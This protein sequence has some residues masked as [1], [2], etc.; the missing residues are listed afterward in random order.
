M[1]SCS[2]IP[3]FHRNPSNIH[4]SCSFQRFVSRDVWPLVNPIYKF[5]GQIILQHFGSISHCRF[6]V[7]VPIFKANNINPYRY[8]NL[9]V[10]LR[11]TRGFQSVFFSLLGYRWLR[12]VKLRMVFQRFRKSPQNSKQLKSNIL[13]HRSFNPIGDY[14]ILLCHQINTHNK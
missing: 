4:F 3:T 7:Q 11:E 2:V 8:F 6:R 5:T 10:P 13:W 14:A 12:G 9:T 1:L